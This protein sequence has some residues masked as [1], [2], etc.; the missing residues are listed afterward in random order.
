MRHSHEGGTKDVAPIYLMRIAAD[1]RPAGDTALRWF[2][3]REFS[4]R[5]GMRLRTIDNG[6]P[7]RANAN[8]GRS[9]GPRRDERT[10]DP[11]RTAGTPFSRSRSAVSMVAP[12]CASKRSTR[13]KAA[14]TTLVCVPCRDPC[15]SADVFRLL[16][17]YSK[18]LP[19]PSLNFRLIAAYLK[20]LLSR[21][22]AR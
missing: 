5:G 7:V 11:M 1:R 10:S 9:T 15:V 21:S 13:A 3:L 12:C 8:F 16:A 22:S 4:S 18:I 2:P 20:M 17:A 6:R 14:T 19:G